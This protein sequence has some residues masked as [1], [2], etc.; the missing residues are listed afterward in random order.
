MDG[1]GNATFTTAALGVGTHKITAVY[2][3]DDNF[4]TGT[5][6]ETTQ[7]VDQ[8]ATG[9]VVESSNLC[10]RMAKRSR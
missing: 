3:G 10:P 1:S 2:E 9:T 6:D 4:T 5:S 8:A 7:T